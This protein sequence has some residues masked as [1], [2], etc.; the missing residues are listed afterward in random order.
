MMKIAVFAAVLVAVASAQQFQQ[1]RAP[2]PILRLESQIQP[3]GRFQYAYETGNGIQ[4]QAVGDQKPAGR[5]GPIQSVQGQFAWTSDD[6]TPVQ[7]SYI[8]DENGYQPRGSALPTPPPIPE[9]ILKSL[10]L[11]A[12]AGPQRQ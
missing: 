9:A 5:D 4:A 1:A 7:I 2:I 11:I 6:G 3:D 10:E 8:A 12:R